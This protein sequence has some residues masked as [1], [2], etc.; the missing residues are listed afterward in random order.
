MTITRLV[1]VAVF[2]A[3]L[4]VLLGKILSPLLLSLLACGCDYSGTLVDSP[5]RADVVVEPPADQLPP[6]I[7]EDAIA[8]KTARA[9]SQEM[10]SSLGDLF[11]D[12]N[13]T[14]Q[15]LKP[16]LSTPPAEAKLIPPQQEATLPVVT[17][18]SPRGC[19]LGD[20][21]RRDVAGCTTIDFQFKDDENWFPHWIMQNRAMGTTCYAILHWKTDNGWRSQNGWSGLSAFIGAMQGKRAMGANYGGYIEIPRNAPVY[22]APIYYSRTRSKWTWP[23]NLRV[24]IRSA[25]HNVPAATVQTWSDGQCIQYH[26]T[27]HDRYGLRV[28]SY[29]T[30]LVGYSSSGAVMSRY[31]ASSPRSNARSDKKIAHWQAKIDKERAKQS[32]PVAVQAQVQVQSAAP[33]VRTRT[34]RQRT[35]SVGMCPTC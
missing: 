10:K 2:S 14:L 22:R 35:Y 11:S 21:I 18:Y 19:P 4:G 20:T 16:V 5:A 7:D 27:Y 6:A 30:P 33:R 26:D 12:L 23:G 13:K 24:H 25:P 34:Y 29:S 15:D 17:V 8:R 3:K 32:E 1:S 9:V 31:D 28:Q